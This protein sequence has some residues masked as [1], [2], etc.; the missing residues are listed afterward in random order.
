MAKNYLIGLNWILL[1]SFL[2]RLILI[3]NPYS[4]S[5]FDEREYYNYGRG[6]GPDIGRPFFILILSNLTSSLIA[7][8]M[9]VLSFG[10]ISIFTLYKIGA[11][12]FDEKT[13]NISALIMALNP[14][15][16][17]LS[18][19]FLTDIIFLSFFLLFIYFM[20]QRRF[21][22]SL[23]FAILACFTRYE[24]FLLLPLTIFFFFY[25]KVKNKDELVKMSLVFLSIGLM[26]Y[27][28]IVMF[29][30][31]NIFL[32]SN[33]IYLYLFTPFLINGFLFPHSVG[34]L[35]NLLQNKF[36]LVTFLSF[37]IFFMATFTGFSLSDKFRYVLPALPISSLFISY[38]WKDHRILII[39]VYLNLFSGML[40][41]FY[42]P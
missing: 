30:Q 1:I 39:L 33:P 31:S 20:F 36:F 3:L 15:H 11:K 24:G 32:V 40:L 35:K 29:S 28:R 16:I 27:P 18:S 17:I 19:L 38:K 37:I 4:Y 26:L 42:F 5:T 21:E 22:V 7:L 41:S 9:I 6:L 12:V 25:F 13:G 8:R 23:L 2:V 34:S 10:L 14:L